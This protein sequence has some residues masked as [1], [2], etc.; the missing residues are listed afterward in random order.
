MDFKLP[1]GDSI[2][3]L[4]SFADILNHSSEIKQYHIYNILSEN[5][6]ILARKNYKSGD[7][8]YLSCF[9]TLPIS[10]LT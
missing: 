7:Q 6:S 3:L 1:N 5:L 9:L 8:V 10:T 2:R 4:V